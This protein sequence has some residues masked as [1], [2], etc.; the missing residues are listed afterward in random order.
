MNTTLPQ[1]YGIGYYAKRLYRQLDRY[2]NDVLRPFDLARSQWYAILVISQHPGLSQKE[3][4]Q[5]LQIEPASLSNLIDSLI[6]KGLIKRLPGKRDKRLKELNMTPEGTQL[7][8]AVPDP[9]AS[10]RAKMLQNIS[11]EAQTTT[12]QTL[13]QAIKNLSEAQG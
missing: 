2:I 5:I 7:L 8:F 3:L 6:R 9:I 4:Q 13:E 11:P 12:I 1:S 10:S